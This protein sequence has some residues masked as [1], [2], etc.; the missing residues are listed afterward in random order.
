MNRTRIL[1]GFLL[2]ALLSAGGYWGY[3]QFLAPDAA[4]NT[5]VSAETTPDAQTADLTTASAEGTIVPIRD[6]QL[7]FTAGGQVAAILVEEG[8]MVTA[9]DPLVRLDDTDQKI[10]VQLAEAAVAQAEAN[11][12]AAQAGKMAAEAGLKAAQIGI[13][14]AQAQLALVEA[15]PSPAQI[16]L[17]EAGVGVAEAGV[18]QAA[19]GR[20]VVLEAVT[21]AQIRA[22]E[23]QLAAAEAA[24]FAVRLAN[25][26]IVQN[27]DVDE[28][29]RE[30]AALRLAAAE[31]RYRAAQ[32]AL[33]DLRAGASTDERTAANS[34]VAV[35]QNQQAAAE[36]QLALLLAGARPEQVQVTAVSV[37]QA[38]SAAAEAQ[39][40]LA[41]AETAVVQAEAAL[42]EA[43]AALTA[44]QIALQK[45]TLT[46]PF[47]G[48]VA[49]IPVRLGEV[50]SPGFPAV[51]LADTSAWLVETTDLS[52]LN[53]VNIRPGFQADVTLDAFPDEKWRGTV[54]DIA[55][56]PGEVRGDVV[57]KVTLSFADETGMPIRWGMTAFVTIDTEQ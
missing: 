56:V 26:P 8:A 36:A 22:A 24:L 53:V 19:G 40:Q 23:A 50:V 20:D 49:N 38:E 6:A 25:E 28:A 12:Q 29:A 47:N 7:A 33:D 15:P 34:A 18:A 17:S 27:E 16:A 13:E 52:E 9:G 31:S 43:Q 42:Q 14:A 55:T 21:S 32:L 39:L 3:R 46:A 1:I 44:A 11:L 10:A 30:Q 2:V 51:I 57:Y 4:D 37:E 35:A 45:R 5:A 41:Q 48:M 54:T